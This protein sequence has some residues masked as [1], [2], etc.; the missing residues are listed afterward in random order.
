MDERIIKLENSARLYSWIATETNKFNKLTL[1]N[2]NAIITSS[3]G[4]ASFWNVKE[5][6]HFSLLLIYILYIDLIHNVTHNT[7]TYV[8]S[9]Q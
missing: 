2:D 8:H 7:Y 4:I 1:P 5:A 3:I 6:A 9:Q